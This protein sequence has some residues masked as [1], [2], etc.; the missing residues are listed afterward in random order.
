MNALSAADVLNAVVEGYVETGEALD[1]TQIAARLGRS[2]TA[3]RRAIKAAHGVVGTSASQISRENHS[4]A[5]PCFVSGSHRVW[6]Y[7]PTLATLRA[8]IVDLRARLT[9]HVTAETG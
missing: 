5:Y 1:V 8:K 4:R 9:R 7:E 2:E 6:V 3:V